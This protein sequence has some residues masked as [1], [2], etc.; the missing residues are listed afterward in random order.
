VCSVR[1]EG[2]RFLRVPQT[3]GVHIKRLWR[4]DKKEW[5]EICS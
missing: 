5:R 1:F 4:F 3:W 2:R